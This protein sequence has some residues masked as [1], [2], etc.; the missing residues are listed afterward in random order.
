[1][2]V[3]F[4]PTSFGPGSL[5]RFKDRKSYNWTYGIY[6]GVEKHEGRAVAYEFSDT[7]LGPITRWLMYWPKFMETA[8]TAWSSSDPNVGSTREDGS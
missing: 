4:K 5:V 8:V 2:S 1:M 7:P 6:R 3:Q